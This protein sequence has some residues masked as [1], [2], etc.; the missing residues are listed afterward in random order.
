MRHS[1]TVLAAALLLLGAVVPASAGPD[2]GDEATRQA[3]R[4]FLTTRAAC[5]A[6]HVLA[7]DVTLGQPSGF[8]PVLGE[9]VAPRTGHT[10]YLAMSGVTSTPPK[11]IGVG[12]QWQGRISFMAESARIISIGSN[13]RRGAWTPMS[14]GEIYAVDLAYRQGWTARVSELAFLTN[15]GRFAKARRPTCSEIPA[16]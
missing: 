5:G 7:I 8:A 2:M 14:G 10:L 4:L 9:T 6:D 13:G 16:G 11:A 3:N 15:L 12:T 1:N